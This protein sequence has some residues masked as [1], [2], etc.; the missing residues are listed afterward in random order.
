[1][2]EQRIQIS[3]RLKGGVGMSRATEAPGVIA[4]HAKIGHENRKLIIPH[5]AIEIATVQQYN[6]GPVTGRLVIESAAGNGDGS[7]VG[8][9]RRRS[10]EAR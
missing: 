7:R 6:Y 5:S 8:N 1:M 2:A 10:V 4:D 9:R 3:V